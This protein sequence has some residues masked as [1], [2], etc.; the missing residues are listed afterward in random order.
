MNDTVE[1]NNGS[2]QANAEAD[3]VIAAYVLFLRRR[4][5]NKNVIAEKLRGGVK[6]IARLLMNS[7]EFTNRI[8]N[9]IELIKAP[10]HGVM[11]LEGWRSQLIQASEIMTLSI[12]IIDALKSAI[13]WDQIDHAVLTDESLWRGD[14]RSGI[15][16]DKRRWLAGMASAHD[17]L[18]GSLD[19]V[20]AETVA[21]WC[22]DLARPSNRLSVNVYADNAFIGSIRCDEFRRDL[23]EHQ[24]SDGKCAFFFKFPLSAREHFNVDR[25]LTVRESVSGRVLGTGTV[26]AHT[27]TTRRLVIQQIANE[28]LDVKRIVLDIER[29]MPHIYTDIGYKINDY[30]QYYQQCI[31]PLQNKMKALGESN[32]AISFDVHVYIIVDVA[33]PSLIYVTLRS[34]AEQKASALKVTLIQIAIRVDDI[35]GRIKDMFNGHGDGGA[36]DLDL[37]SVPDESSAVS[38]ILEQASGFGA[39][40]FA[41]DVL[42]PNT[43]DLLMDAAQDETAGVFYFDDDVVTD[44]G[45]HIEPRLKP[46]FDFDF[47]VAENYV[48][49][50]FVWNAALA[51]AALAAMP[52]E[53]DMEGCGVEEWLY[54]VLLRLA[55][56]G[57]DGRCRHIPWIMHHRRSIKRPAITKSSLLRHTLPVLKSI[58]ARAILQGIEGKSHLGGAH[59]KAAEG[60]IQIDWRSDKASSVTVIIP[61]KDEV[62]LLRECIVSLRRASEGYAGDVEI[63][64][65]DNMSAD[66]ETLQFL[67]ALELE[68]VA[69]TI[70]YH[71]AFNW[72]A[73]NNLAAERSRGDVLICLNNDTK[74]LSEGWLD[75]LVS[76]AS[77]PDVGAV[78]AKLVYADGTVQHGGVI[79]GFHGAAGHDGVGLHSTSPGYLNH[80]AVQRNVS[81]VTGACL[82]TRKDVWRAIGGFDEI[83]FPVAFN[84]TD[85]CVRVRES[86]LK[87]I[88]TP[89]ALAFHYE[90]KSRGLDP[91]GR[92]DREALRRFKEKW[93]GKLDD[94]FYNRHFDRYAEPYALLTPRFAPGTEP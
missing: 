91:D 71:G 65:V 80:L 12:R 19:V 84:D 37:T 36:L 2:N 28:I 10:P 90:S 48:G 46:A 13:S 31:S 60:V 56:K 72:A 69:R 88:Y 25:R 8:A 16:P 67:E 29:R 82:A 4:P 41:G 3:I 26:A 68:G 58:G 54:A 51:M 11:T 30:T 70:R 15:S 76:Q 64:I 9:S 61:T 42:S 83:N 66:S 89:F 52:M 17:G 24:S 45:R 18:Q 40:M 63:L 23:L 35:V 74:I 44:E 93:R 81:A 53:Q 87:V 50:F 79:I 38:A 6:N 85:Y 75:E 1:F 21:G 34:L 49:S 27:N 7:A 62:D 39:V 78:G 77:R 33:V 55:V 32:H 43:F 22:R 14:V 5:E 57:G 20:S 73:A 94:P 92:K 59:D 86:G 47:C